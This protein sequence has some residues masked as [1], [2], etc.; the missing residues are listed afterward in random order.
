MADE[1]MQTDA[2]SRN[3]VVR[4]DTT[5]ELSQI[6]SFSPHILE[7][8]LRNTNWESVMRDFFRTNSPRFEGFRKI[9]SDG[10]DFDIQMMSVYNDFMQG[11]ET[12]LRN[13]IKIIGV[14]E[15]KF[16]AATK[17]GVV[18][19][20]PVSVHL[21]SLLENLSD[22]HD[23]GRMMED[24]FLAEYSAPVASSAKSP[25]DPTGSVSHC[26]VLWDIENIGVGKK[27]GGLATIE[28]L[29]RF[30]QGKG[31][32]GRGIDC[33]IT[34]FFNPA[35]KSNNI[36][37][38][39]V[40]ELD[41][42]AVEIVW[43]SDK[44]EDADR[45]LGHRIAQELQVLSP[46]DTTFVIITSD[47]DFRHHFQLLRNSNYNIIVI[48]NATESSKWSATMAMHCSASYHWKDVLQT[49]AHE[50]N[51]KAEGELLIPS[52]V[53][54]TQS[55][56]AE[57]LPDGWEQKYDPKTNKPFY[58]NHNNK[59]THWQDP[60]VAAKSN[61]SSSQ[62]NQKVNNTKQKKGNRPN[63]FVICSEVG[64]SEFMQEIQAVWFAGVC[65]KWKNT[66]GFVKVTSVVVTD[67]EQ[68]D[69]PPF[70]PKSSVSD[71]N[72]PHSSDRVGQVSTQHSK[73]VNDIID[74]EIFV[75]SS[76]LPD[77]SCTALKEGDLVEMQISYC[78]KGLQASTVRLLCSTRTAAEAVAGS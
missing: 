73:Y 11:V 43:V 6:E 23:F 19:D 49:G 52:G 13:Q 33:R 48:H 8:T 5:A 38:K 1:G 35:H 2:G 51:A 70:P 57:S 29:Q 41:K 61:N 60:R 7:A 24:K 62:E 58:V 65:Q 53:D 28:R 75:H 14:T 3:R 45:K 9:L 56:V 54:N 59:S 26:R 37:K 4:S 47:Q 12:V 18:D 27:L 36:S 25:G 16:V 32:F 31:L 15:E 40:N 50:N 74:R 44:R 20:N 71:D 30:L 55:P 39:V 46:Q 64:Q 78:K 72:S 22:F 17:C 67:S 68:K 10:G 69:S 34:A 77:E 76:H 63:K 21:V 66:F 42:A